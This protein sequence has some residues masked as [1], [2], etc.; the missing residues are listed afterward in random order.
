MTEPTIQVTDKDA[1]MSDIQ[2]DGNAFIEAIR[3][4]RTEGWDKAAHFLALAVAYQRRI[5]ELE[6]KYEPKPA[7]LEVVK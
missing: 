5:K 3:A 6:D 4:Q 7:A 1:R 2:P